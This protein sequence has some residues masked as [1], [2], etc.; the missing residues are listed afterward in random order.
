M[1]K[2][3]N[4]TESADMSMCAKSFVGNATSHHLRSQRRT[5]QLTSQMQPSP[6]TRAQDTFDLRQPDLASR[7]RPVLRLD[8]IGPVC[9]LPRFHGGLCGRWI[10]YMVSGSKVLHSGIYLRIWPDFISY[11]SS[12]DE[13]SSARSVGRMHCHSLVVSVTDASRQCPEAY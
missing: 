5:A 1:I 11:H 10:K 2:E 7:G 13:S 8:C 12:L 6:L 9:C 4:A 3:L